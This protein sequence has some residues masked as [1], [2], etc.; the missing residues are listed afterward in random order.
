MT[1]LTDDTWLAEFEQAEDAEA[2]LYAAR[3]VIPVLLQVA[4]AAQ[5][6]EAASIDVDMTAR[7]PRG[8]ATNDA[9]HREHAARAAL[10]AALVALREFHP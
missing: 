3:S 8:I 5:E 7:D 2:L 10:W 1:D 9:Y 6:F 4:R